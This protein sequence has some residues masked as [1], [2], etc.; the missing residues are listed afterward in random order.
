MRKFSR[1]DMVIVNS[2][3]HSGEIGTILGE[4]DKPIIRGQRYY[5]VKVGALT[6]AMH[7]KCLKHSGK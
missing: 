4:Y 7:E 3:N 2:P 6:W 1:G 5:L